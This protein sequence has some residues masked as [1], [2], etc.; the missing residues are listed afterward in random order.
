MRPKFLISNTLMG[1]QMTQQPL[2]QVKNQPTLPRRCFS[3]TRVNLYRQHTPPVLRTRQATSCIVTR[4]KYVAVF[5]IPRGNEENKRRVSK[6][7]GGGGREEG[8]RSNVRNQVPFFFTP[9]S[10]L[11]RPPRFTVMV[12]VPVTQVGHDDPLLA[13]EQYLFPSASTNTDLFLPPLDP[14]FLENRVT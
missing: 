10:L 7:G 12:S 4:N 5:D 6:A 11:F 8:K 9:P 1:L 13:T 3:I 14:P 2:H